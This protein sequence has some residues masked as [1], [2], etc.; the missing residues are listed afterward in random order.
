[1][2]I[3]PVL[4]LLEELTTRNSGFATG[5]NAAKCITQV[6]CG[7][8]RFFAREI[9]RYFRRFPAEIIRIGAIGAGTLALLAAECI[10]PDHAHD[11]LEGIGRR[12]SAGNRLLPD[13][14]KLREIR[15][16]FP[17]EMHMDSGAEIGYL[18]ELS[19]KGAAVPLL[20]FRSTDEN[21]KRTPRNASFRYRAVEHSG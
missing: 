17:H 8:A 13:L 20:I 4:L 19:T 2:P 6:S 11:C 9:V 1:M 14:I 3:D 21:A 5:K 16:N 18:L 7:E 10:H 15:R 12:L